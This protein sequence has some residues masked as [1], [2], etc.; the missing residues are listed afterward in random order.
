MSTAAGLQNHSSRPS[1]TEGVAKRV[2]DAC[3]RE[4]GDA[5][6]TYVGVD[7]TGRTRVRVQSSTQSS[8]E[9][10]QRILRKAM[11]FAVVRTSEDV[12]DGS[13]QAE[14]IVPTCDDEFNMAYAREKQALSTRLLSG[15]ATMLAAAGASLLIASFLTTLKTTQI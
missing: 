7:E 10:M 5:K 4:D 1:F 9:A 15:G 13:L 8:V 3:R 14:L 12:L 2:L 6:I 11:P